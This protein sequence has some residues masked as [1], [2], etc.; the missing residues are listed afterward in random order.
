MLLEV[1]EGL[2]G[3]LGGSVFVD[4][5]RAC[6]T[7]TLGGGARGAAARRGPEEGHSADGRHGVRFWS[8]RWLP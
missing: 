1:F 6:R 5:E 7:I 8:T 2:R 4:R 3:A